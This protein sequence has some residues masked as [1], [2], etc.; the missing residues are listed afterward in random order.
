M[1]LIIFIACL[2][3]G[4]VLALVIRPKAGYVLGQA[5][6]Y[7]WAALIISLS[8]WFLY[9]SGIKNAAFI[10]TLTTLLQC[11]SLVA[12]LLFGYLLINI[13]T[14]LKMPVAAD[15]KLVLQKIIHT[16]IWGISI[17]T[18]NAFIITTFGKA[19]YIGEMLDFFKISGYAAWFLYFIMVVEPLGGLGI[20]LHFKLKT[21]PPAVICLMLIMVGAVYTHWHNRDPFSDSYDAVTQFII[22]SLMLLLYYFERNAKTRAS[23]PSIGIEP[24]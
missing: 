19:K 14:G 24:E 8:Y 22:L 21:G 6:V 4:G 5:K 3:V 9:F 23:Y 13:L 16:T 12:Y 10:N 17:I 20:L 18:G 2:I 1:I 7:K 11:G 15:D